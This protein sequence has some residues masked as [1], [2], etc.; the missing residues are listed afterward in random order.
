MNVIL[1]DDIK[2]LGYKNDIVAVKAGY[3]RNYLIPQGLAVIASSSNLKMA[4]ENVRQASHKAEKLKSDAQAI[5][6]KMGELTLEIPAKAGES[7]KIFGAVTTLQV[8]EALKEKGFDIDRRKISFNQDIKNLGDYT[9]EI[10]LH[11]DV[12]HE[13]AIKVV[14]G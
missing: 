13:I 12:K 6:A 11:K 9:A 7:G 1:K 2:G 14:E 8:A 4:Q 3:G 10:D 5:A